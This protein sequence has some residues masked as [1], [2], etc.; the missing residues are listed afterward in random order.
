MQLGTE[1]TLNDLA[2]TFRITKTGTSI[3]TTEDILFAPSPRQFR[4][5]KVR[6]GKRVETPNQFIQRTAANLQS[7]SEKFQIQEARRMKK[8]GLA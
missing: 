8:L 2:R 7:S 1:E 6:G 4:E 3:D 5:F